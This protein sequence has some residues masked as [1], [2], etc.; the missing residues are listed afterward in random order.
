MEKR[1]APNKIKFIEYLLVFH[2]GFLLFLAF[3]AFVEDI[4]GWLMGTVSVKAQPYNMS[5]LLIMCMEIFMIFIIGIFEGICFSSFEKQK[6]NDMSWYWISCF[7][8]LWISYF[9]AIEAYRIWE[10][11]FKRVTWESTKQSFLLAGSITVREFI[12]VC[13]GCLLGK[14]GIVVKTYRGRKNE[15]KIY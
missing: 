9:T 7:F 15:D 5:G 3:Y 11:I 14:G 2:W 6:W 8:V 13:I 4:V 1:N 12:G 10:T